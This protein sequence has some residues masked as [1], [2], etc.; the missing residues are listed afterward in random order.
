MFEENLS[1]RDALI[2]AQQLGFAE[3]DPT[4]DV[5]G[6]DAVHKWS[7]LLTH[8]YGII[9][10][11]YDLVFNGIQHIQTYDALVATERNYSIKLVA[12]A[13]KLGNGKIAAFVLPQFV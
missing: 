11:Y 13:K 2:L 10:P 5:E 9:K 4:L 1:F 12:Q 3:T 7:F 6:Y 8:A